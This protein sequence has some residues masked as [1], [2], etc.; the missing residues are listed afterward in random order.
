[1]KES[2]EELISQAEDEHRG[3]RG[4]ARAARGR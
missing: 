4:A 3:T 1:M 2:L